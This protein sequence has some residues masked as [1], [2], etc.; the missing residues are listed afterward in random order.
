MKLDEIINDKE[1]FK[2]ED[3]SINETLENNFT[4]QDFTEKNSLLKDKSV[5]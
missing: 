3:K 4:L 2:I 5:C 1:K